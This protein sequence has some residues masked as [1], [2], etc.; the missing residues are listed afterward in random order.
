M[1]TKNFFYFS[2]DVY[3]SNLTYKIEFIARFKLTKCQVTNYLSASFCSF[4]LQFSQLV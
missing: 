2:V 3:T 1:L 4:V